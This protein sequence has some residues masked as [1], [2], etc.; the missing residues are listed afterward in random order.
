MRSIAHVH[1]IDTKVMN[2]PERVKEKMRPCFLSSVIHND[3]HLIWKITTV[4]NIIAINN[5]SGEYVAAV[6]VPLDDSFA[7]GA[8]QIPP[9]CRTAAAILSSGRTFCM[10]MHGLDLISSSITVIRAQ[11]I[12]AMAHARLPCV[13]IALLLVSHDAADVKA[14]W[15]CTSICSWKEDCVFGP[16][17]P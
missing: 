14:R 5:S 2:Q 11:S 9:S 17:C 6:W 1:E 8:F 13:F 15:P 7:A 10:P 4:L 3:W 12:T 16:L